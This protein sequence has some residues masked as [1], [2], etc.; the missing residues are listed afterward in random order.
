[1]FK[2]D[3]ALENHMAS[4]HS[5]S[6]ANNLKRPKMNQDSQ[7]KAVQQK[8]K[9]NYKKQEAFEEPRQGRKDKNSSSQSP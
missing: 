9:P 4:L 6:Q 2:D 5:T 1:M 8:N 7:H 3:R